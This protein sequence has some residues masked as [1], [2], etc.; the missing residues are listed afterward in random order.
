MAACSIDIAYTVSPG[1]AATGPS[2]VQSGTKP[3]TAR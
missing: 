3:R 1:F 2:H